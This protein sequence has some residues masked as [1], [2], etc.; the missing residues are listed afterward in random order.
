M[1]IGIITHLMSFPQQLL[2]YTYKF[3]MQTSIN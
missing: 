3:I 2:A 1:T